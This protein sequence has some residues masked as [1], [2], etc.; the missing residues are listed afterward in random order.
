MVRY[1]HPLQYISNN[2]DAIIRHRHSL[3]LILKVY[4]RE[5]NF[6]RS[7]SLILE[8]KNENFYFLWV[9]LSKRA[10]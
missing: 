7:N 9:L 1:H 8:E 3:T 2:F 10:P 4:F 6:Q 5:E